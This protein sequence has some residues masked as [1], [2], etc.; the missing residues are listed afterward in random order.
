MD[1]MSALSAAMPKG[2][3]PDTAASSDTP[4]VSNIPGTADASGVTSFKDYVVKQMTE[5]NDKL[6][7]SDANTRDLATGAT[8]DIDKVTTSVEEANLALQHMMSIRTK[9][10]DA[11][12]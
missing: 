2:I 5:V 7:V 4:N 12:Q 6:N 8:D 3:I 1:Y 11:Y 9:L 10:L